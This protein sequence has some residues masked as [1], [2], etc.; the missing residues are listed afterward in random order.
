MGVG[1]FSLKPRLS[2]S[3]SLDL[4]NNNFASLIVHTPFSSH[5]WQY[6]LPLLNLLRSNPIGVPQRLQ[7]A[8]SWIHSSQYKPKRLS[9]QYC[10]RIR[11]PH[12]K[13]RF[14]SWVQVIQKPFPFDAIGMLQLRHSGLFLRQFEQTRSFLSFDHEGCWI[15]LPPL[16]IKLPQRLQYIILAKILRR[17]DPC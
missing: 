17:T 3:T 5:E 7:V 8:Y 4:A 10:L 2:R 16:L 15:C 14:S 12:M 1:I 6:T 11:W 9:F 13:H